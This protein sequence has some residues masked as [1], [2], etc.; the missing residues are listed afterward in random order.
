MPAPS[1]HMGILALHILVQTRSVLIVHYVVVV[2]VTVT[3][4]GINRRDSTVVAHNGNSKRRT[5]QPFIRPRPLHKEK[6]RLAVGG[7]GNSQAQ[8]NTL[9]C[10]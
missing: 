5:L 2:S 7:L 3:V 6:S 9:L 1:N 8:T 10:R 4:V